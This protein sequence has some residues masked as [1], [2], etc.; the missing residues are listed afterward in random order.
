MLRWVRKRTQKHKRLVFI[1]LGA[2]T[3]QHNGPIGHFW[4]GCL[5]ARATGKNASVHRLR[6][7][8][9]W[10]SAHIRLAL[11]G[12]RLCIRLQSNFNVGCLVAMQA[13]DGPCP[14][15]NGADFTGRGEYNGW[16]NLQ[17]RPD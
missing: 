6:P 17:A 14:A 15:G 10:G 12:E 2:A 7:L 3:R 5:L 16:L 8:P 11:H 4:D 1:P 9:P 13:E